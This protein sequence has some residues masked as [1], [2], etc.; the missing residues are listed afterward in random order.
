MASEQ[1]GESSLGIDFSSLGTLELFDA[2]AL[3]EDVLWPLVDEIWVGKDWREDSRMGQY[4]NS[5]VN[6]AHNDREYEVALAASCLACSVEVDDPE[7]TDTPQA[8]EPLQRVSITVDELTPVSQREIIAADTRGL[9]ENFLK[10]VTLTEGA[11]DFL[12]DV[13]LMSSDVEI[14]KRRSYAFDSDGDWEVGNERVIRR[15]QTTFVTPTTLFG[16][17]TEANIYT[18]DLEVIEIGCIILRASS[19]IIE[20]LDEVRA[21]P[22]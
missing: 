20:A 12:D 22:L 1:G 15:K 10:E 17:E 4:F 8:I 7:S 13:D 3:A 2:D 11:V 14:L 5:P 21:N 9:L 6:G 19:D 18:D 16:N